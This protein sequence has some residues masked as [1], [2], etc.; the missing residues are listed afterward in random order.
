MLIGS[1]GAGSGSYGMAKNWATS[2][3]ASAPERIQSPASGDQGIAR[4]DWA[5]DAASSRAPAAVTQ[6]RC[7]FGDRKKTSTAIEVCVSEM[8]ANHSSHSAHSAGSRSFQLMAWYRWSSS[9]A[10]GGVPAR[11]ASFATASSRR[12]DVLLIVGRYAMSSAKM[13]RPDAAST[14]TSTYPTVLLGVPANPRVKN[15]DP[16]SSKACFHV[17]TPSPPR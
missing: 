11:V 14:K 16:L 6:D 10:L 9:T 13:P 15:E 4:V 1:S 12:E 17:E 3:S 2:R 8:S 5:S 7:G